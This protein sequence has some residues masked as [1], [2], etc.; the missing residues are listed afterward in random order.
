ML[1]G[2]MEVLALVGGLGVIAMLEVMGVFVAIAS[3]TDR[4][5]HS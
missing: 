2:H 1:S 3:R 4:S 5:D